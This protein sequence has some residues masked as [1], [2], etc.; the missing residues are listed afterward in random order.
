MHL[1]TSDVMK[2]LKARIYSSLEFYEVSTKNLVNY[3]G[4]S[5]DNVFI[6]YS[7]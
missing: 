7:K 4:E 3:Q 1:K 2:I 6:K 5:N